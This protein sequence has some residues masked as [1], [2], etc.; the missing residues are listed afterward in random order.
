MG[1]WK[2]LAMFQ[3][4]TREGLYRPFSRFPMVSRR[5]PTSRGQLLLGHVAAGPV[6][7]DPVPDH[8]SSPH[9]S[10]KP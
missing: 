7:L 1:T 2:T 8:G 9:F 5:T 4:R 3:A 10:R 6:F